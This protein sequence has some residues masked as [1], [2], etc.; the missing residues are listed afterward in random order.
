M[1]RIAKARAALNSATF[2]KIARICIL[3]GVYVAFGWMVVSYIRDSIRFSGVETWP[4]VPVDESTLGGEV[5]SHRM[6]SRF[7]PEG[8]AEIDTRHVE[9]RYTV[10]GVGY[11]G[12]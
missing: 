6:G 1:I 10:D 8:S 12:K 2:G 7:G 5:W 11:D 9:Y 4:S 3:V